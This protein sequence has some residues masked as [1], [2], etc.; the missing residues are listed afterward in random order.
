M[1]MSPFSGGKII[2]D[3]WTASLK[4]L[5][6]LKFLESL[7]TFDKDNIPVATMKRIRER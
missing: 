5:S 2:E 4:M 7:K 6:D 3:Y 1:R